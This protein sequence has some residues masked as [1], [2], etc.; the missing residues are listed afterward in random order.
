MSAPSDHE[1]DHI[2]HVPNPPLPTAVEFDTDYEAAHLSQQTPIVIDNGASSVHIFLSEQL[3]HIPYKVSPTSAT[4]SPVLQIPTPPQ[5]S[6]QDIK[7]VDI[8]SNYYYS[9]LQLRPIVLQNWG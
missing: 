9:A 8:K 7:S 6:R 1:E 4:A 2:F 5:T 3:R